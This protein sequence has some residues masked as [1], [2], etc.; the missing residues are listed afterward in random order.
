ML[1]EQQV[2]V[3]TYFGHWEQA[4]LRDA[5][6]LGSLL[7]KFSSTTPLRWEVARLRTSGSAH[8]LLAAIKERLSVSSE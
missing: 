4:V 2:A 7:E 8:D 1:A 3:T 6:T 5:A